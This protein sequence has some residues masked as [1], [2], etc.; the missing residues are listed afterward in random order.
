M[1]LTRKG[2]ELFDG[3]DRQV[4]RP[5]HYTQAAAF[6]ADKGGHR[7]FMAKEIAEQPEVIGHT[8]AEYADLSELRIRLP[9]DV[10]LDFANLDRLRENHARMRRDV[11]FHK[12][13]FSRT[14]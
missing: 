2:F 12:V 9:E 10:N 4:V 6:L 3:E 7:H 5:L 14:G 8:L 11:K 13:S 1:V